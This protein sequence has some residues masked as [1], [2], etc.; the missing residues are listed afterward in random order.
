MTHPLPLCLPPRG[1]AALLDACRRAMPRLMLA[2]GM[3]AA[4]IMAAPAGAAEWPQK[5][6]T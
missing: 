5:P 3:I 1:A 4:S 6:V 2:A